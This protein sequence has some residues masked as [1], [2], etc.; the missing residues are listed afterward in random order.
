MHQTSPILQGFRLSSPLCY[1]HT[2]L[3]CCYFYTKSFLYRLVLLFF[4]FLNF[5][6]RMP[7]YPLIFSNSKLLTPSR[8][9]QLITS[10]RLYSEGAG[11]L[12]S[13]LCCLDLEPAGTWAS[14]SQ[15]EGLLPRLGPSPGDRWFLCTFPGPRSPVAKQLAFPAS[16]YKQLALQTRLPGTKRPVYSPYNKA[17]MGPIKRESNR[18]RELP[19]A[20]PPARPCPTLC[21]MR[22]DRVMPPPL[23]LTLAW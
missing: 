13:M 2:S 11:Q 17:H 22:E 15:Q 19:P 7:S 14:F 4:V 23:W 6:C 5:L 16:S 3:A 9:Q 8:C 10:P 1:L 12:S 21:G 20:H 18:G